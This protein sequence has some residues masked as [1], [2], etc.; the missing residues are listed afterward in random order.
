MKPYRIFVEKRPQY[1]SEA[2]SLRNELN[3]NL[4][5]NIA[6]LRFLCVY[7]L[8]GFSDELVADSS[9]KVFAEPAT[10]KVSADVDFQGRPFLA[11]E[12]LPGQFDQRAAAAEEC[13]KLIQPDADIQIRSAKLMIF[14]SSV[15][16]EEMKKIAHYCINAVESRQKDLSILAAPERAAAKPVPV[17]EGFREITAESAL[18]FCKEKGL[19]MNGDDLMEVVKYFSAEGRDPN[20]TELRILDT[21]W[22]DH[23]RHTTFTTEL[24]DI[25]VDDS[26]ATADLE[27]S[28]RQWHEIRKELGRENK[29][30]A[31]WTSLRSEHA[32]SRKRAARRP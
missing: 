16:E 21:Y 14:D 28:L 11:I 17:L 18:A 30:S 23:C 10:D 2:E 13:V 12:S 26:F 7:D 19:A 31:S 22:S 27:E 20:E 9:Y 15:G 6:D 4:G 5:L 8:F 29:A 25:K 1:R 3:S 24:T 32:I